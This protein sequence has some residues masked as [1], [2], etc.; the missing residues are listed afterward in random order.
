LFSSQLSLLV[1][2]VNLDLHFTLAFIS[3]SI[4]HNATTPP[5]LSE[6]G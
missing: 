4:H 3:I 1:D 2:A 6:A 5:T